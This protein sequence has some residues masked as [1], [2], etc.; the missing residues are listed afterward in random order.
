MSTFELWA[1]VGLKFYCAIYEFF[2]DAIFE[3][4]SS[5]RNSNSATQPPT[6]TFVSYLQKSST[7]FA[8]SVQENIQLLKDVN[9]NFLI[10]LLNS[11]VFRIQV[12]E[13]STKV[14]FITYIYELKL[15]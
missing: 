2:L 7:F 10:F 9:F 4:D 11:L 8:C 15:Y 1:F 13:G 6:P 14:C 3:N 12:S 5:T